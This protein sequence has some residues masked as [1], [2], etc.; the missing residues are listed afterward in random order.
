MRK[1]LLLPTLFGGGFLLVAITTGL[2]HDGGS[3]LRRQSVSLS[4]TSSSAAP[5]WSVRRT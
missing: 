5:E 1:Q 2:T 3:E 4:G